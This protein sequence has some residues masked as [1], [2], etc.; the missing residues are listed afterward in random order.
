V[1]QCVTAHNMPQPWALGLG[2]P[3][4]FGASGAACRLS[5]YGGW[6]EPSGST[7]P[8]PESQRP[9]RDARRPRRSGNHAT[10]FSR[11]LRIR[12][13]DPVF[14]T[15]P[16]G[17]QAL[18]RSAEAFLT[19][20]SLRHP[21]L[22]ADLGGEGQC[23]HPGGLTIGARRL[24]QDMLETLTVDGVQYRLNALRTIR[25]PHQTLHTLPV[26]GP[27]DVADGLDGT[28]HQLRNRLRRQPTGT[29]END[30]GSPD[31]EGVRGASVSLQLHTFLIGQ[32]S[33]KER[34]FH[35]PSLPWEA[36]LHNNSCGDAL[37]RAG[38]PQRPGTASALVPL[39]LRV[40]AEI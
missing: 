6:A 14:G 10:F 20:T 36:R 2:G 3:A 25:V 9:S 15:L 26:K 35:N 34:W 13:R 7:T 12:T 24:M 19:Q 33:N 39:C 38:N 30:L 37:V 8:H 27:D 21:L 23:P 32:G 4:H 1:Y 18:Q 40:M 11:V 29:R 16:I 17:P 31:P 22:M 28:S 5:R